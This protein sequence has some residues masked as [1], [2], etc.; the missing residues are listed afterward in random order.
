MPHLVYWINFN[1]L[2]C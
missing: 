2:Y 1:T